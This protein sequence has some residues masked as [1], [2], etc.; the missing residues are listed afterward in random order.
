MQGVCVCVC[1]CKRV[2][3]DQFTISYSPSLPTGIL[4]AYLELSREVSDDALKTFLVTFKAQYSQVIGSHEIGYGVGYVWRD[5]NHLVLC[6]GHCF[7][8]VN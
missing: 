8:S 4:S 5:S 7:L 3:V 2:P 1:V 6:E